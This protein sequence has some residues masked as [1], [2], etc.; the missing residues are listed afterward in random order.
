MTDVQPTWHV[1]VD[2]FED[3][4]PDQV[5]KVVTEDVLD[6]DS[7]NRYLWLGG[8]F[9]TREKAEE[10]ARSVAESREAQ[11][12]RNAR[13]RAYFLG[14]LRRII[15]IYHPRFAVP[16]GGLNGMTW[17]LTQFVHR[18]VAEGRIPRDDLFDALNELIDARKQAEMEAKSPMLSATGKF[19][20]IKLVE[21][22]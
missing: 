1:V 11:R 20:N 18:S 2:Q 3:R 9:D 16:D 7:D 10:S 19:L 15:E 8:E 13:Y 4:D 6:G 12:E 22:Q 5:I 14:E 17:Q 21:A